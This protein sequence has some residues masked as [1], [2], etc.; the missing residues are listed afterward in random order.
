MQNSSFHEEPDEAALKILENIR[1]AMKK[2][3]SRFLIVEFVVANEHP[4]PFNTALDMVTMALPGNP[5]SKDR[6]ADD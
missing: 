2:D 6:T 5:G 4:D 3:Y 1:S